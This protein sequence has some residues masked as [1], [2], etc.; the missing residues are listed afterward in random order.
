[1]RAACV[2]A[3][4]AMSAQLGACT[5]ANPPLPIPSPAADCAADPAQRYLGAIA[6]DGL[7]AELLRLTGARELRW[8]PPGTM[9]T[10]EFKQG[11]L[12]VGYDADM[13]VTSIACT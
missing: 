6:T 10:M 5:A 7:G 11:R 2:L 4:G 1:M 8:V 12:T 3:L 13:K 9:V